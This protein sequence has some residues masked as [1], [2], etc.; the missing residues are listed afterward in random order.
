MPSEKSSHGKANLTKAFKPVRPVTGAASKPSESAPAGRKRQSAPRPDA[1]TSDEDLDE[2]SPAIPPTLL[3]KTIHAHF[4]DQNLRMSKAASGAVAKYMET[5]VREALARA[6]FERAEESE[7]TSGKRRD[8]FLEVRSGLL[9]RGRYCEAG[10]DF[11][12]FR[13]R[14]LRSLLHSCY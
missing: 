9:S 4:E 11:L 10:A 8:M 7:K 14:T 13:L 6:A 5:F 12:P 2:A 1:A 3:T